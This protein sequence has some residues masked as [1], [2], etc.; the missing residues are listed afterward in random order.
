[1]AYL[2]KAN[3]RTDIDLSPQTVV[4]EVIQNVRT[5]LT[6][7]KYS[8]PLDRDFGISGTVVDLPINVAKARMTSEIFQAI[9]RYE[10]RASV[11]SIG[12][13]GE[14]T[15]KLIPSVEVEI[16]EAG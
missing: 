13:S 5:I 1:M 14:E 15:G 2:I 4:D 3:Q 6:T 11:E 10:P 12:F 8:I 9:K 16:Y 7:V